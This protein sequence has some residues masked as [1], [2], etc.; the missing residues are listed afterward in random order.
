MSLGIYK[1]SYRQLHN[2]V[3]KKEI[4]FIERCLDLNDVGSYCI[5]RDILEKA[6]ETAHEEKITIPRSLIHKL[7]KELKNGD[8]DIQIF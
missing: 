7:K 8:F 4:K 6:E 1:L 2:D 3:Y 5:S